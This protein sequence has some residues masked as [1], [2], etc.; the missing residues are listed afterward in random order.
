MKKNFILILLVLMIAGCSADG[1]GS[2]EENEKIVLKVATHTNTNHYSY[3]LGIEPWAKRV[4]ELT[5]GQVEFE[6][7]PNEQLGKAKDM[8]SMLKNNAVDIT[9][10]V[11]VQDIM[12]L[13]DLVALPDMYETAYQGT[14]AYWD[15]AS[16]GSLLNDTFLPNGIRPIFTFA[17]SPSTIGTTKE[18]IELVED[19][20]G[21]RVR[22]AGGSADVALDA[23][24]GTPVSIGIT[25]TREALVKG[26]VNGVMTSWLSISPYQLEQPLKY[27][28]ENAP[29][30]GFAGL[31]AINEKRFQSLPKDIQDAIATANEEI[32]VS[33]AENIK[34]E[35]QVEIDSFKEQGIEL[36]QLN[37]G[38]VKQMK[39]MLSPITEQW[40]KEMEDKGLDARKVY[41]EFMEAAKK[42]SE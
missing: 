21:M 28:V 29:L 4:T 34:E 18:K 15:L 10:V 42:H 3:R 32:V 41:E 16:K 23:L 33:M 14:R 5:N 38:T 20:K 1:T 7:F 40:I 19:L 13:T 25:E 17:V 2:A 22:S 30:N 36:Y 8:Y 31:F 35:E 39:E 24:K 27:L 26:M 11:Y 6:F 37:D 9:Y 12:P